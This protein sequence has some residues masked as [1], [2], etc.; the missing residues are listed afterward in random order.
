MGADLKDFL[1]GEERRQMD[2]LL[3]KAEARMKEKGEDG[4]CNRQLLLM[5]CQ[6]KC[7][8]VLEKE[9]EKERFENDIR[10]LFVNICAFCKGHDMCPEYCQ[11]ELPFP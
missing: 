4:Y 5:T 8:Q 1:T 9:E 3:A 11:D 10:K 7:K 2:A 6:C